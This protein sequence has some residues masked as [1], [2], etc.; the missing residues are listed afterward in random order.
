MPVTTGED[1]RKSQRESFLQRYAHAWLH[2]AIAVSDPI[3][4]RVDAWLIQGMN[5]G[6]D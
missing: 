4:F 1:A 3:Q 2:D 6:T 5:G